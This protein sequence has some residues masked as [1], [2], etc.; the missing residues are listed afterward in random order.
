MHETQED[1]VTPLLSEFDTKL[2]DLEEKHTLL[3][4]R[5]LLIGQNLIETKEIIESSLIELKASS[6]NLNLEISR[7]KGAIMRIGE[8]LEKRAR[9]NELELISKQ[10]K[11]FSPLEFAR[12]ED[13]KHLIKK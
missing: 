5:V 4:E 8:E 1:F 12:M 3:K 2:R 10:L 7:I 6:E 9:K 11:M 13:I